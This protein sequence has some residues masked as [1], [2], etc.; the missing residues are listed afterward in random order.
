[1]L[2]FQQD[3]RHVQLL[4]IRLFQEVMR[5]V[6]AKGK[7]PLKMLVSK[8]L[9]PLFFNCHD[10]NMRVAEVRTPGRCCPPGRGLSCLPAPGHLMG[11]SL[12]LALA[13]GGRSC[14]LGCG[15]ISGSL[16]LCRP[17]VKRCF[18]H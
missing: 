8:S 9:L 1:M 11:S 14:A 13:Q 17:L 15:A 10:E 16:L 18:L 2:P 5:L 4:S 7:K 12:L 6:A 3:N